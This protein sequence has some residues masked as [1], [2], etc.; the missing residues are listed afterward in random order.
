MKKLLIIGGNGLVGS[1]LVKYAKTKYDIHITINKNKS[2]FSDVSTTKIEL[3]NDQTSMIDLIKNF[4]PDVVVSTAAH[5]SVDFC[6]TDQKL[7]NALH[8]DAINYIA[9]VCKQIDTKLIFLST[10]AVFDGKS[11]MKYTEND[12]PNP[13]NYYGKT[14]LKAENIVLQSSK[15]NVVL[16]T[17]VI[18]G[19]HKSSK[20]TN[21]ILSSLYQNKAVDPFSD[22]YNTPTLVDDLAKSILNIIEIDVSGLFHAVGNTC[23]NRY[24]FALLLADKF[25]LEKNLVKPVTSSEKKQHA[26]RPFRTCLDASKLEKILNFKFCNLDDGVSFVINQSKSEK[27][28]DETNN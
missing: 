28:F 16:R 11:N 12:V 5:S 13:A 9:K 15:K 19:W 7:A 23:I 17:A 24:E 22:Q 6:E 1:T 18:Y 27:M 20:F 10:D 4:N 21:W 8:V 14:K 26:P 25:D 3:I 2:V